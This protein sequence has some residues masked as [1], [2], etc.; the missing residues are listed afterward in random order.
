LHL[1]NG[2][3]RDRILVQQF[4]RGD[5]VTFEELKERASGIQPRDV[6]EEDL[7]RCVNIAISWVERGRRAAAAKRELHILE[8]VERQQEKLEA[9]D[10]MYR[11]LP[12]ACWMLHGLDVESSPDGGEPGAVF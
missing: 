1:R 7:L 2:Q 5:H 9:A 12:T 3:A 11:L 8:S 6:V 4:N 10:L